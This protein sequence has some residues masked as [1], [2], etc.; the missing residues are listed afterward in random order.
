MSGAQFGISVEFVVF[1]HG[2][3]SNVSINVEGN[4]TVMAGSLYGLAAITANN[5]TRREHLDL[6]RFG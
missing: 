5:P 4:A 1:R 3:A 6:N 2:I